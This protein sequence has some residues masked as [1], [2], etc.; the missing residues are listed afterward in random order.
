MAPLDDVVREYY[1]G[2]HRCFRHKEIKIVTRQFAAEPFWN[3]MFE[4]SYN[5]EVHRQE[6]A[7]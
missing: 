6:L 7:D 4:R 3:D 5:N 2:G 1:S